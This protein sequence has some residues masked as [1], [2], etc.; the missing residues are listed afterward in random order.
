MA[1]PKKSVLETIASCGVVAIIRTKSS[2]ELVDVARALIDGGICVVEITMTVPGALDV[3]HRA[4]SEL[5]DRDLCLGAGTVPDSQTAQAAI[6][7]GAEFI[8]S[9]T[10]NPDTVKRCND[11]NVLV[12]P[13]AFTPTEV[14]RAWKVGADVVKI[15]PA[16]IGGPRYFTDLKGPMPDIRLLP[17]GNVNLESAPK[18]IAAGAVAVGVGGLLFSKDLI[19]KRAFSQITEN[20]RELVAVVSAARS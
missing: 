3:I 14:E 20:A 7:A 4:T 17:T 1:R 18:Y 15:F 9:P 19:A 13:G 5:A 8:V 12:L 16:N 11:Q 2:D 10:C 6:D